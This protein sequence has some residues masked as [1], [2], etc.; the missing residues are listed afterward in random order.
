MGVESDLKGVE[1]GSRGVG[2]GSIGVEVGICSGL[3]FGR[4]RFGVGTMG[5]LGLLV[6][7]ANSASLFGKS[8]DIMSLLGKM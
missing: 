1:V 2:V 8:W 4:R 3:E 6:A 7:A 5:V